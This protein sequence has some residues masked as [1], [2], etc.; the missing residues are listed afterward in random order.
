LTATDDPSDLCDLLRSIESAA[1]I[2]IL[3]IG[4]GAEEVR[5]T[6]DALV[7]GGDGY[8]Q[9][10]IEAARVLA[11]IATYVGTPTPQLPRDLLVTVDGDDLETRGPGSSRIVV[12]PAALP[13]DL[14]G[15]DDDAVADAPEFGVGELAALQ[16]ELQNFS[17]LTDSADSANKARPSAADLRSSRQPAPDTAARRVG[18]DDVTP[19]GG[20][21]HA[22]APVAPAQSAIGDGQDDDDDLE[23]RFDDAIARVPSKLRF[24]QQQRAADAKTSRGG[25]TQLVAEEARLKTVRE[26]RQAESVALARL[27]AEAHDAGNEERARI[28]ALA[29]ERRLAEAELARLVDERT[30]RIAEE[31]ARI[32]AL[33]AERAAREAEFDGLKRPAILGEPGA[34]AFDLAA[35]QKDLAYM[36]EAGSAAGVPMGATSAAFG[37]YAAA[38]A[39]GLGAEDS[40]AVIRFLA[41]K[42]TREQG[43]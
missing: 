15:E 4:T 24:L 36:L 35:M 12:P 7:V 25:S 5:S 14:L 20:V 28:L 42:L 19:A 6:S 40:V 21:E 32:G 38:S 37:T 22:A 34:V 1:S 30:R 39:A 33:A 3:F 41:E 8:F 18:F 2:P 43:P 27:T 10:P 26:A 23:Q 17:G 11:K 13:A 29:D 16:A 9:L 31:E